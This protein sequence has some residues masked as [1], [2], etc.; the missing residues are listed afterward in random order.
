MA[1]LNTDNPFFS[2]MGR[3]GDAFLLNLV[4]LACS[5]PVLTAGASATALLFVTRRMAAGDDYTVLRD[6]RR[7]LRE[8]FKSATAT[9]MILL[10]LALPWTL[11]LL[12][13]AQVPDPMGS[14]F[15]GISVVLGG[16]WIAETTWAFALLA[17]YEYAPIPLLRDAAVQA[18]SH[19][20]VSLCA[21]ALAAIMP[22]LWRL[23]LAFAV[24]LLP[25][26]LLLGGSVSAYVLSR[27]LLP[28]YSKIEEDKE[29]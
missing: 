3:L 23:D 27:L 20:V 21:A 12:L 25:F 10:L 16:F 1:R 4:W 7:A 22:L 24:Y 29:E 26:W 11:V 17:R 14:V 9:W 2:F 8:N 19:P 15:R 13:C 5:L 6:F 18:V 28:V